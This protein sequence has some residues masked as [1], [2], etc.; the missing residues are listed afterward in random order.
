MRHG[1]GDKPGYLRVPWK[2][3]WSLLA[4][5]DTTDMSQ[6]I[7]RHVADAVMGAEVR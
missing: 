4:S 3:W 2:S 7:V 1:M 5:A 6:H